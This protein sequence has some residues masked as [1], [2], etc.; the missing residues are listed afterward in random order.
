MNTSHQP[1]ETYTRRV[2]V[3][4]PT[5]HRDAP[6]RTVLR[7]FLEEESYQPFELIVIDQSEQHDQATKA[8]LSAAA[9]RMI[10]VQADYKSLPRARNHGVRLASGDIVVFVDDDA[11]PMRGFLAAHVAPYG[12]PRV[13]GVT[14]PVLAPGQSLLSQVDID[15]EH[16]RALR[17]KGTMRFDVDFAFSASWATGG[18]MS[19]RRELI[20]RVGGFDENFYGA[21][22]GED[23]EFSHRVKR[24]GGEIHY[25]PQ[26][27]IVH[28]PAGG[29]GCH[30]SAS[31]EQYLDMLVDNV[32]YFW[33]KISQ[34]DWV[35]YR[36]LW[37]VYR[38]VL[39]RKEPEQ[40]AKG[41]LTV[42]FVRALW[43]SHTRLRNLARE[44]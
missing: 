22:L 27:S 24:M 6:L 28:R 34:P 9:H 2:S 10:Y 43:R 40:Q 3:I 20:G 36:Q 5:L 13:V 16:Y 21:A 8:F 30:D 38:A 37:R 41:R 32:N 35:R 11:E 17:S 31:H 25:S 42:S 33:W 7:Y 39:H 26:A 23:A 15:P 4:I 18:N 1:P 29:G 12:D 44:A 19:F 14:G